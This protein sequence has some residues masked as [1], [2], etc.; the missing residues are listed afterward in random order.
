MKEVMGIKE[1][2]KPS[3]N[4]KNWN[5]T[6]IITWAVIGIIAYIIFKTIYNL[7]F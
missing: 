6:A 5:W 3:S 2:P 1:Q 4:P 7:I